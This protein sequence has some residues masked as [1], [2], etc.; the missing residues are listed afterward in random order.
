MAFQSKLRDIE[1]KEKHKQHNMLLEK[2]Q[3]EILYIVF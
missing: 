1:L 2:N 3:K